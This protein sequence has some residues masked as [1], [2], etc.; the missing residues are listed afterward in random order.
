MVDM[1]AH[2]RGTSLLAIRQ[3]HEI[4]TLL[5]QALSE[6]VHP[7]VESKQSAWETRL[8]MSSSKIS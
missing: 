6:A 2:D 8:S 7:S 5:L 3:Y 4:Y 1:I